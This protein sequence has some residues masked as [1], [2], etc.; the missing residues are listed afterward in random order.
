MSR[1]EKHL[2]LC[3]ICRGRFGSAASFSIAVGR[4]RAHR[5]VPVMPRI[6][7]SVLRR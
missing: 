3:A 2:V 5:C 1:D 4:F 7:P 6:L